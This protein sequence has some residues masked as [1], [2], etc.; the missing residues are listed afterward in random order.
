[1]V[2][3]DLGREISRLR[4]QGY[5]F[6]FDEPLIDM[7]GCKYTFLHPKSTSG[8]LVGIG[9]KWE[10]AGKDRIKPVDP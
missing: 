4:D 8:V 10:R 3:D 2:T 5:Q 6:A 7:F 1:L 9:A